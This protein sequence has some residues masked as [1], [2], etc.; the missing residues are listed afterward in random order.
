MVTKLQ[1]QILSLI[2]KKK[3]IN[4]KFKTEIIDIDGNK[5]DLD[6]FSYST[7]TNIFFSKGNIKIID[8]NQNIYN[9]SEIYIDE[10]K[11]TVIGSDVKA[12]LN[13]NNF[14]INSEN[15]PRFFAN[16]IYLSNKIN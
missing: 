12:F 11:Q 1:Q 5:I 15:D 10:T 16:T 4:S 14:A 3:T 9:F 7:K 8:I 13:K 6:N 2:I